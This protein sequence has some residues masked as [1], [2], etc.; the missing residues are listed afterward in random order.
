MLQKKGLCIRDNTVLKETLKIALEVTTTDLSLV[1]IELLKRLAN[2]ISLDSEL[3]ITMEEVN[4]LKIC[5]NI[6]KTS[7]T[8]YWLREDFKIGINDSLYFLSKY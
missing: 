2:R 8:W 7:R 6:F 3:Q 4:N 1:Q 5:L